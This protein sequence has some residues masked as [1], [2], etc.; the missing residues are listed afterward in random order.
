MRRPHVREK[1]WVVHRK[2]HFALC[3]YSDKKLTIKLYLV[4]QMGGMVK[5]MTGKLIKHKKIFDSNQTE[6]NLNSYVDKF[7]KTALEI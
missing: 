1:I 4:E 2:E 6:R 7:L 3:H 5:A